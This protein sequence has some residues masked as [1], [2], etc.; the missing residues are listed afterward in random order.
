MLL[1]NIARELSIDATVVRIIVGEKVRD[2]NA[3]SERRQQQRHEDKPFF[4]CAA[5][6][7]TKLATDFRG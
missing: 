4:H 7:Q 2:R 6:K 5:E 3:E 1:Q